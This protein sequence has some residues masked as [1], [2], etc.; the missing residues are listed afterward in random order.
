[1]TPT[2]SPADTDAETSDSAVSP[3]NLTVTFST[4]SSTIDLASYGPNFSS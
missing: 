4:S 1:M 3:P 2:T